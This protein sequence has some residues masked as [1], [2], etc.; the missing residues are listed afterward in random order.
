MPHRRKTPM[1][2][3][4][5]VLLGEDLEGWVR[6]RRSK[7]M[8]WRT[9]AYELYATTDRKVLVSFETLRSWFPDANGGTG[10]AA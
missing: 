9:I 7:G 8:S 2:N 6:A 10:E 5:D 1:H 3:L 4:A